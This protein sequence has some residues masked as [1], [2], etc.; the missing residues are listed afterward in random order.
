MTKFLVAGAGG[1]VD[2]ALIWLLREQEHRNL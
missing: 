1:F 2:G